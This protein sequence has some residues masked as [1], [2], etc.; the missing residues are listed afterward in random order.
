MNILFV[1]TGNTC[2]SPMAEAIMKSKW[3]EESVKSAGVFAGK[4]E[5]MASN[6]EVVLREKN[7]TLDHETA[8]ITEEMLEWA[9]LVLTMTDRHKQTLTLQYPNYESKYYTL[10]EYVLVDDLK[11]QELKE[12]YSAFEEKRSHILREGMDKLNNHQMEEKLNRELEE[13]MRKIEQMERGFPDINISDPFGGNVN[14]YRETRDEL[15]KH[16]ELLVEKLENRDN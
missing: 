5:P 7:L 12:S 11:W 16:I 9:D 3:P 15:E 10:K 1:C 14:I 8:Q 2:R 13:D 4:G 6:S